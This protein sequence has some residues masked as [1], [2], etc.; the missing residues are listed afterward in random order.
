MLDRKDVCLTGRQSQQVA[1]QLH[2]CD[3]LLKGI[4]PGVHLDKFDAVQNLIHCA[5]TAVCYQYGFP[6]EHVNELG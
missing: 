5:N 3:F 4:F 6:S 1:T 2:T